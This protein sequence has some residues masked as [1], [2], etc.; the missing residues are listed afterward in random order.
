M[1]DRPTSTPPAAKVI[2]EWGSIIITALGSLAEIVAMLAAT[3]MLYYDKI[4]SMM[5]GGV[6]AWCVGGNV[7]GKA[8]G[9]TPVPA[10]NAAIGLAALGAAKSGGAAF[11]A[12]AATAAKVLLMGAMLMGCQF[13]SNPPPE[14][15][16]DPPPVCSAQ[17]SWSNYHLPHDALS[18][19][20]HNR[21]GYAVDLEAWNGLDTPLQLRGSGSGFELNVTEGGDQDSGW[22]GLASV[23]VGAEGHISSG[24]VTM[25]RVILSRYAGTVAEHVLCQEVGHLLGLDHQRDVRDSCMQDCVGLRGDA[26]I[27]CLQ[28]PDGVTPNGHDAEQL[29]EIYAH[30]V[31]PGNPPPAPPDVGCV[32]ELLVHR[33]DCPDGVCP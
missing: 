27:A 13:G 1:T 4:D 15:P 14:L 23:R 12:K 5:W 16:P 25:N 24:T 28:E 11:A 9:K 3:T 30:A 29:R 21:S 10:T 6:M 18:P 19:V 7:I 22:L 31:D 26:W 17:H 33:L 32:G 2:R 20:V 8:R